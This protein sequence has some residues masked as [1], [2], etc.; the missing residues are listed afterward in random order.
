MLI[1]ESGWLMVENVLIRPS[2]QE[3]LSCGAVR[4]FEL[5]LLRQALLLLQ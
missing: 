1:S 3:V 5:L 2:Y 4:T